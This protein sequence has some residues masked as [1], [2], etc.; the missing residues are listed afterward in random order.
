M[1]ACRIL[2]CITFFISAVIGCFPLKETLLDGLG[3][4]SSITNIGVS[5]GICFAAAVIGWIYPKVTNVFG[6][7]GTFTCSIVG[8]VVPY[9]MALKIGYF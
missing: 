8:I 3:H 1:T 2:A 6:L 9:Y 7:A 5:F 4:E